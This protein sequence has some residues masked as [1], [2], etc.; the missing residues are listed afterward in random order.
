MFSI[1]KVMSVLITA[2]A[3]LSFRVEVHAT[4]SFTEQL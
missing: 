3:N 4:V 2:V 1:F